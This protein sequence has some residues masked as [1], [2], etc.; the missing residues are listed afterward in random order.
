MFKILFISHDADRAGAQ[1]LLLNFLKW[2]NKSSLEIEFEILFNKGGE[3]KEEFEKIAIANIWKKNSRKSKNPLNRLKN[4]IQILNYKRKNF[5]LIY[6]NTIINGNILNDL[7]NL[8]IPI[9]TH[10]HEM[11]YW[12]TKAGVENLSLIKAYTTKFIAASNAVK[13]CLVENYDIEKEKIT[14][15]H[16]HVNFIELTKNQS[17]L[18]VKKLL[19]LSANSIIVG[20]SGAETWRK[21]KDLFIPLA[22]EIFNI[23]PSADIHFVWIGGA[24]NYELKHDLSKVNCKEKI[25]FISHLPNANKYFNEFS[26]FAMLS[27]EDPFPVVNLEVAA[28]GVPIVCFDNAGGTPELISGGCGFTVPY[29][30]ISEFAK[31]IVYI[32]DNEKYRKEMV[33][34]A[35]ETIKTEYDINIIGE[36]IINCIVSINKCENN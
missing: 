23:K 27:R 14:V 4:F 20:A 10:V 7:Q 29:G 8:S 35:V 11:D 36:K 30:S 6:S 5:D 17:K 33:Q 19:N 32:L 15:I 34:H 13:N 1:L 31:K 12:I 25:H 26:V 22:K 21:G 16:E 9:I 2:L 3:L 18:S 24:L 28:L